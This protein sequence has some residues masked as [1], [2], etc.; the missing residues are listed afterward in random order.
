MNCIEKIKVCNG[1]SDCFD[2]SDESNCGK[3]LK[4]DRVIS[5]ISD[6]NDVQETDINMINYT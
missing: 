1:V 2:G 4:Y 6:K 3:E 5:G